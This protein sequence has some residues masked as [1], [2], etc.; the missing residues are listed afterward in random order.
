MQSSV[1][2]KR[3]LQATVLGATSPSAYEMN[4]A[5]CSFH[6]SRFNA[7]MRH[8]LQPNSA[9]STKLSSHLCRGLACRR[10]LPAPPCRHPPS[11]NQSNIKVDHLSL[12]LRATCPAHLNCLRRW[13][14]TQS[15]TFQRFNSIS[16]SLV[17]LLIHSCH[18]SSSHSTS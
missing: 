17:T 11:G 6:S 3:A 5:S 14:L 18:G 7:N 16:I 1:G 4:P 9:Y 10:P 2:L 12:S 13:N 15:S 8:S